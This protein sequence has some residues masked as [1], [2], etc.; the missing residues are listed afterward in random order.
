MDFETAV[1]CLKSGERIKRGK[2][3]CAYLKLENKRVKMAIGFRKPW[4]YAFRNEDIFATDWL[5]HA[6]EMFIDEDTNG[7]K[8]LTGNLT[9]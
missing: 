2:W 4:H 8:P 3:R 9:F 6:D 5:I 7:L 1:S